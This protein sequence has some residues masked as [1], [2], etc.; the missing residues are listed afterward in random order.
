M[1]STASIRNRLEKSRAFCHTGYRVASTYIRAADQKPVCRP[2][3]LRC[4]CTRMRFTG[5]NG[6]FDRKRTAQGRNRP[7][8]EDEM[9]G[10][11][12]DGAAE[13]RR[14]A[15]RDNLVRR[16]GQ[17]RALKPDATGGDG[18]QERMVTRKRKLDGL[19][20]RG[21]GAQEDPGKD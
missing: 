11:N 3:C 19:L 16:K 17:A 4:L 14:Q 2:G 1:F 18:G 15:L 10:S 20:K 12:G 9:P 13:R 7:R 6:H 8:R 21:A 5:R